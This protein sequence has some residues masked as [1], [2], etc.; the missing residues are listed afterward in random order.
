VLWNEVRG[1]HTVRI[2]EIVK[3][4]EA[5]SGLPVAREDLARISPIVHAHVIPSGTYHFERAGQ[6]PSTVTVEKALP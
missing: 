6:R 5:S 1:W 3:G 4:L 2:A